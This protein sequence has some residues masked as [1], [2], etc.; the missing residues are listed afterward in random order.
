MEDIIKIAH[1]AMKCGGSLRI[2]LSCLLNEIEVRL[3]LALCLRICLAAVLNQPIP[4]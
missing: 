1:S 2:L 4:T 3:P